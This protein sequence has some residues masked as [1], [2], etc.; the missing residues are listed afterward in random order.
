VVALAVKA[1]PRR[2]P[3]AGTAGIFFAAL[4]YPGGPLPEIFVY[5]AK[6]GLFVFG[7]GLAVVPFLYGGVVHGHH[8]LTDS[9]F[10]DAVAVA[11]IT[12]GPVV[13]TVA[14]IGYLVHGVSGAIAAAA[15]IF[16]PVYLV[17]VALAPSYKKWA[18]NPQL[19][20]F[21]RGVTAAATG[22]IAGAVIVLARR[23]VTDLP[24]SLIALATL[25]LLFRWKIP[26]PV[27]I[28]G[29]AAI[30]LVLWHGK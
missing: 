13:I 24:T 3:A 30:G 18:K 7:S 19:N 29:S 1:M 16:L 22:G 14:F 4:T 25:L 17:V 15:G 20:A 26:E 11:M 5:F 23:S 9:Q 2:I 27:L 28:V 12:P 8:W 21:V 10:V 6:A